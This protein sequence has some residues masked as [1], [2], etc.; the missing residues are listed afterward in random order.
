MVC[1]LLFQY[2]V[3]AIPSVRKLAYTAIVRQS[4]NKDGQETLQ[5]YIQKVLTWQHY[6]LKQAP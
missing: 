1:S 3:S 4:P 2:L 6:A 5:Y